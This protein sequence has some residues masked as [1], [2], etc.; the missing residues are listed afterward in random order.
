VKAEKIMRM[1]CSGCDR[2]L[3]SGTH[4]DMCGRWFYNSCGNVTAQ[5]AMRGKWVCDKCRSEGLRLLEEK[6][7]DALHQIEALT[8]KNKT[9]EEKL[10]L[11][12][13]GRE[14]GR[15]DTVSGHLKCGECLVLEDSIVRNVGIE[16]SDKTFECFPGIRT[17]QLKRVIEKRDLGSPDSIV[18]HV[19]TNDLRRTGNLD[20]VMGESTIV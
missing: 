6:L 1:L 5:V 18:N 14:V 16:C 3:N 2:I 11:S 8:K 9:L 19:D 15:R 10:R 12:T 20:Y 13:A 4:F 17:E 7:Q